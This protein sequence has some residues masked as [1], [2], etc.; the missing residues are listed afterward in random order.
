LQI[1]WEVEGGAAINS[2][3]QDG[4]FPSGVIYN[5]IVRSDCVTPAFGVK[6]LAIAP[7]CQLPGRGRVRKFAEATMFDLQAISTSNLF[8]LVQIIV[9][10]F[11][12]IFSVKS[13][14]AA[15]TSITLAASNL[16]VATESLRTAAQN[17]RLATANAQAQLYNQLVMQA[18]DLQFKFMD[19]YF[20]DNLSGK[21]DLFVGTL[22]SYYSASFE[23]RRLFDLPESVIKLLDNDLRELLRQEPVRRKWEEIKHLH[24]REFNQYVISLPGV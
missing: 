9:I 11:G 23:L 21:Q 18:R 5:S 15:R 13:L 4:L 24:S 17:L 10:L 3:S 6:V 16:H 14:Q 19:L 22:L 7:L 1:A 12:F 8:T 20:S 2:L